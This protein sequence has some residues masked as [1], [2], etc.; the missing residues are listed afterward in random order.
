MLA[1][2]RSCAAIHSKARL[3]EEYAEDN[4]GLFQHELI[5]NRI[6]TSVSARMMTPFRMQSCDA[7]EEHG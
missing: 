1:E 7:A 6:D 2:I 4:A 5:V 3:L